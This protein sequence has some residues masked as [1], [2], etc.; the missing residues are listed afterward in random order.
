MSSELEN[1]IL[2][3]DTREQNQKRIKAV[4]EWGQAHGAIVEHSALSLCDYRLLG[5]F[6]SIPV[7]IGI[8]AK[9]M[10]DI[11]T[12]YSELSDKLARSYQLYDDVALFVEAANYTFTP[13]A[14][15]FHAI[16]DNPMVRNG[17]ANVLPL[18][19]YENM[20]AS[21]QREGIHV[22]QLRSET[23]FPYAISG[24]L[25]SITKPIHTGLHIKS[26]DYTSQY[27]N[28]LAKVPH[29][30]M[31]RATKLIKN[32]PAMEW[33]CS[34]SEESLKQVLGKV[35][36]QVYEFIHCHDLVT[37]EWRNNFHKDG[38]EKD[39][40]SDYVNPD[41]SPVEPEPEKLICSA[42]G[43]DKCTCVPNPNKLLKDETGLLAFDAQVT[44]GNPKLPGGPSPQ[45]LN[46]GLSIPGSTSKCDFANPKNRAECKQPDHF[47]QWDLQCRKCKTIQTVPIR[48]RKLMCKCGSREFNTISQHSS[49]Q[50]KDISTSVKHGITPH[51][52][53]SCDTS[54]HPDSFPKSVTPPPQSDDPQIV[55]PIAV[56][57][58]AFK[59]SPPAETH[60]DMSYLDKKTEYK[61]VKPAVIDPKAHKM[62]LD[63]TLKDFMADGMPHLMQEIVDYCE[64]W[65]APYIFDRVMANKNS[66]NI[67][68][69]TDPI[70]NISTYKLMRIT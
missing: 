29:I 18:A 1:I 14:D 34:A 66:G 54:S 57:Q 8:E 6:R 27:L 69:I 19:V 26:K 50:D 64:G 52:S 10:P 49:H 36:S 38:T 3:I 35:G 28:V 68:K 12:S 67:K 70:T 46:M 58:E 51:S 42:C 7:N 9:A 37:D 16:I 30:S 20:L 23:H 11:A 55:P 62:N 41:G 56:K 59:L 15:N 48:E 47:K 33:L 21:F 4:E 44:S 39:K 45:R 43:L 5:E 53:L 60:E 63:L 24:L 61:E 40:Q 17:N 13:D 32:Y 31:A 65:G 2:T 22:R 25:I